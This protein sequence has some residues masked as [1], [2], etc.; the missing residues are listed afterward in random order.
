MKLAIFSGTSE[1]T[2]DAKNRLAVPKKFRERI[3][4]EADG[5]GLYVVPGRPNSY[6]WLYT[7]RRF[8]QLSDQLSSDLRPNAETLAWEQDFFPAAEYLEFDGQGRVLL[9]E[10]LI[11]QAGLSRDVMI[12]G[13]RDH[14]EIRPKGGGPG[15]ARP[16]DSAEL[17]TEADRRLREAERS[18]A[19]E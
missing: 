14:L 19:A 2:I 15:E 12:C 16:T 6:L 11:Q 1:H 9:P 3:D 10:R 18:R 13:V 7:E 17:V 8:Q 5:P 4:P